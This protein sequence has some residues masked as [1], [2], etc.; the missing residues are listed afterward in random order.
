MLTLAPGSACDVCLEP[1][2]HASHAPHSIRCGHVFCMSCLQ[3][4]HPPSCPLCR[5]SFG[6]ESIIKLHIDLD[7]IRP[8]NNGSAPE[9]PSQ[10]ADHEARRLQE[11]IADIANR[12]ASEQHLRNVIDECR[13]FLSGQPRSSFQDLR[14]S[15]RMLAYMCD[16]RS[17]LK[18]EKQV[19]DDL[20]RQIADKEAER[21]E[22]EEKFEDLSITSRAAKDT[23]MAVELSLRE[24]CDRAQAAYQYMADR[25]KYVVGEW[26]RLNEELKV[27]RSGSGVADS[28]YKQTAMERYPVPEFPQL[29]SRDVGSDT[30][31]ELESKASI[32]HDYLISPLPE[33]TGGLPSSVGGFTA[34]P[35]IEEDLHK[36]VA[37]GSIAL[38]QADLA[39]CGSESYPANCDSASHSAAAMPQRPVRDEATP[40][41]DAEATPGPVR[42]SFH[43]PSIEQTSTA[44]VPERIRSG[45]SL[46]MPKERDPTTSRMSR[47]QSFSSQRSSRSGSRSR[48]PS[49]MTTASS[50]PSTAPITPPSSSVPR[51]SIGYSNSQRDHNGQETDHLRS[52]LH[53]ILQDTNT[54][55]ASLPN[56]SPAY[57]M[58]RHTEDDKP[59]EISRPPS[60]SASAVAHRPLPQPP[61]PG[62]LAV[63]LSTNPIPI[64]A[65]TSRVSE[66]PQTMNVRRSDVVST[67]S[68]AA[69]ALE[70]AQEER[71]KAERQ[72]QREDRR[73]KE[74]EKP[75]ERPR[76]DSE[77]RSSSRNQVSSSSATAA[78]MSSQ[79]SSSHRHREDST[80]SSATSGPSLRREGSVHQRVTPNTL[81]DST[82]IPSQQQYPSHSHHSSKRNTLA[83]DNRVAGLYA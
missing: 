12:G 40:I 42:H 69:L 9:A 82:Y 15:H 13:T 41:Q 63:S 21:K 46:S 16:I 50:P 57:L 6:S 80:F 58:S 18:T 81:R 73:E 22:W 23:A 32:I 53:D 55:S 27:L 76:V 1:F 79:S 62:Q 31:L 10:S 83:S 25:Y 14:V 3:H 56:M 47:A 78:L 34:L 36:A 2:D 77:H 67:A 5:Q 38:Q 60:R 75:V 72:R 7:N 19:V 8:L 68:S 26:G 24:H 4:L 17:K 65:P 44:P 35:D 70:K 52:R 61:R 29:P 66:Q 43:A 54:V 64:S 48:P 30:D 37:R 45:L 20:H 39:V 71:R 74:R 49:M 33:F 59:M 28:E 11:A 51:M